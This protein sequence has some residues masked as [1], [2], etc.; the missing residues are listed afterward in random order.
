MGAS[1][2]EGLSARPDLRTHGTRLRALGGGL[3]GKLEALLEA[4]LQLFVSKSSRL[5]EVH[6][7]MLC[8]QWRDRLEAAIL[9]NH[10]DSESELSW[11]T[12]CQS[13]LFRQTL[14]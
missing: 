13:R 1:R 11:E 8:E 9:E 12:L 4:P 6:D 7:A 3:F 2:S 10:R 14:F 5:G